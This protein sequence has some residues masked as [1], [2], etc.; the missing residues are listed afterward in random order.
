[1]EIKD[2]LTTYWSQVTLVSFAIGYLIKRALDNQ[3]KKIEIN[4]SLFQQNRILTVN[5]FFS[6]YAKTE[7]MWNQIAIFDILSRKISSKEI[8]TLIFPTINTLKETIFELKIYFK[9]EDLYLFEELTDEILSINRVLSEL[10]FNPDTKMS[11][12]EKSTDFDLYK[13]KILKENKEKIENLC[14]M[15][16]GTFE[17]YK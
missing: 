16:R 3:S 11:L 8:D 5:K 14:L 1:M 12:A 10:Y 2:I 6:N 9:P 7:L 17:T 15:V 13:N 4:H